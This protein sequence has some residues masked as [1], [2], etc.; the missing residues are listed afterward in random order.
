M[1]YNDYLKNFVEISEK[2]SLELFW[3]NEKVG[4]DKALN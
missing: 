4:L 3:I 2:Y 1:G